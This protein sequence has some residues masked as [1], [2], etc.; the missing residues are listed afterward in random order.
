MVF[1]ID[2]NFDEVVRELYSNN[3]TSKARLKELQVQ[4]VQYPSISGYQSC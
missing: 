3:E 1:Q 2:V 4:S